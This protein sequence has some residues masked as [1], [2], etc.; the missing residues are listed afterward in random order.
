MTRAM[1]FF[2]RLLG[3]KPPPTPPVVLDTSEANLRAVLG[4][5]NVVIATGLAIESAATTQP[6]RDQVGGVPANI[7]AASWP[8]CPTC[9]CR[10]TFIAQ[11]AVG[12]DE[13]PHYPARGSLAIF[14]C[15][16]EPPSTDELCETW[17][18]SGSV[19]FFV[20]DDARAEPSLFT[21]EQLRAIERILA[22]AH[23]DRDPRQP[24]FLLPAEHGFQA[25]PLLHHAYRADRR[26]VVSCRRPRGNP[27][28]H[29]LWAA[30]TTSSGVAIDIGGFP[31]WIQSPIDDLVCTCGAPMVLIVQYEAFDDAIN[32][33]D[34]GR[35]Y[36]FAC[37][38][39][40]SP[41][42]FTSRW[43]CC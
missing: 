18:P 33:G 24:R 20:P 35:A 4:D 42:A 41:T 5:D 15:N 39:R 10:M 11:L 36:I 12:P 9:R 29:A 43:D 26:R 13:Q 8:R 23:A 28:A 38:K 16:S 19:C 27:A 14:R 31:D 40:C 25:R 1:G 30:A 17:G 6:G 34:A 21:D 7:G 22:R 3:K 37:A 2:D 32:L